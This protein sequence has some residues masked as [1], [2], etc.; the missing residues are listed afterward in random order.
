MGLL[1]LSRAVFVLV[2]SWGAKSKVSILSLPGIPPID[3]QV[4]LPSVCHPL[5]GAIGIHNRSGQE[6]GVELI[7][8]YGGFLV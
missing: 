3:L 5:N 8:G 7:V 2:L 4:R 1:S 6:I